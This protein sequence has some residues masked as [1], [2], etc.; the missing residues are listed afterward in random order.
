MASIGGIYSRTVCMLDCT[1][2]EQVQPPAVVVQTAGGQWWVV[3]GRQWRV[4]TVDCCG[5]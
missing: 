5:K 3:M 2:K 1:G 4:S